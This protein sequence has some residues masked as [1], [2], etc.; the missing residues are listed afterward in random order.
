LERAKKKDNAPIKKWEINNR[1]RTEG[2]GRKTEGK[3]KKQKITKK[4][5]NL[6]H[7]DKKLTKN[8]QYSTKNPTEMETPNGIT[9]KSDG[10]PKGLKRLQSIKS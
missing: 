5:K 10:G 4:S 9:P 2:K 6:Q 1:K 8:Q 3:R 7:G